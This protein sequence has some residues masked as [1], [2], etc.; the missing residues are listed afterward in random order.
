MRERERERGECVEV[1]LVVD[2][3][4]FAVP[5]G[6]SLAEAGKGTG[7]RLLLL[8]WGIFF[9]I[10]SRLY[11]DDRQSIVDLCLLLD[12]EADLRG[13]LSLLDAGAGCETLSIPG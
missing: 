12:G 3:G 9:I 5:L 4:G 1:V 10:R 8:A 11:R 2:G 7:R 6:L 13:W